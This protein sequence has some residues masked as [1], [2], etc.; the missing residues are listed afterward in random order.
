MGCGARRSD[1]EHAAHP[2]VV[3]VTVE[4]LGAVLDVR[5]G[6]TLIQAAWRHGYRWPTI[7]GG[8]AAC[9]LCYI[10]LS[11]DD[12]SFIP[13]DADELS[14]MATLLASMQPE[15]RARC[16]LACCARPA[17]D[18]TVRKRGVS[19]DSRRQTGS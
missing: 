2:P 16:R 17:R 18:T 4:P 11:E 5:P 1:E 6:E 8:G 14:A 9:G 13:P 12:D 3:H 7:C 15:R 19:G 10:E